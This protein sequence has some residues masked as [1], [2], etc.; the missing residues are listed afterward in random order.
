MYVYVPYMYSAQEGQK[1]TLDP[2]STGVTEDVSEPHLS[3]ALLTLV[4]AVG[5]SLTWKPWF[6]KPSGLGAGL[7]G[8]FSEKQQLFLIIELSLQPKEKDLPARSGRK[9]I[10]STLR[11]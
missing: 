5:G 4:S 7:K 8:R 9:G 10:L 11:Y 3:L 6:S 2:P 1:R